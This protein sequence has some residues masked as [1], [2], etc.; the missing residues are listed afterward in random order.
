MKT[1]VAAVAAFAVAGGIAY[2]SIP[3]AGGTYHA[4]MLKGIGTI[5]IIDPEKQRCSAA[6]ETEITFNQKGQD[7]VNGASPTVAQVG[8]GA[9]CA[10]GGAAIT[11]AAGHTAFVCNGQNGQNGQPFA[12][13]FTS[14]NGQYSLTVADTGIT[15][16]HGTDTIKLVDGD[17]TVHT[18]GGFRFET[19]SLS[20]M[21]G[22]DIDLRAGA[23]ATLRA[24]NNF[25]G[26]GNGTGTVQSSATLTVNGSTVNINGCGGPAA[27]AGDLV[28]GTAD[29]GGN[30]I[31]H[32]AI[33]SPTV[34]IG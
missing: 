23:N 6:L 14:P 15:I 32:I 5:R 9:D 20:S 26:R 29:P 3:D 16:A 11:D 33:G 21:I 13:T 18:H 1:V 10:N 22:H 17:V 4:C 25:T 27:R 30:V 8:P 12:G 34:C 28:T 19:D 24:D 2:A 7:G 31:A